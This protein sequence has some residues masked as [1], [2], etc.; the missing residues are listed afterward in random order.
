M[1]SKKGPSP[2]LAPFIGIM[3]LVL[4]AFWIYLQ[5]RHWKEP[6]ADYM[7]VAMNVIIPALLWIAL[8]VAIWM[9]ISGA[10]KM[11][12]LLAQTG[13]EAATHDVEHPLIRS[14]IGILSHSEGDAVGWQENIAG[15][16]EKPDG[17]VQVFVNSDSSLGGRMYWNQWDVDVQRSSWRGRAQFGDP[18]KPGGEYEIIGIVGAKPVPKGPRVN[19]PEDGIR[20]GSVRVIRTNNKGVLTSH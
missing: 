12:A 4:T 6:D 8:S 17:F 10:R 3:G 20:S 1:E 16:I 5:I 11:R 2:W 19:L 13:H 18:D 7:T 14:T 9:N 15:Y